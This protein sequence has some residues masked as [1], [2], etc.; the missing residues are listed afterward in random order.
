[1]EA[2]TV[3]GVVDYEKLFLVP[4]L[5]AVF[6]AVLMLLFFAPPLKAPEPEP[7]PLGV[8]EV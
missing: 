1:M 8:A 4:A 6:A 3:D 7:V 5:T 2:F